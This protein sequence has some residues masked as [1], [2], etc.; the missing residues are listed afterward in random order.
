MS[1]RTLGEIVEMISEIRTELRQQGASPAAI[2]R[3]TEDVVR[4][5]WPFTRV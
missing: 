4:A 2:D 5:T 3:A 1:V